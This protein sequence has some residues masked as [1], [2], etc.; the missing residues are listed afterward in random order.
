MSIGFGQ[1]AQ[2]ASATKVLQINEPHRRP[3]RHRG[4]HAARNTPRHPPRG[5]SA[6]REFWNAVGLSSRTGILPL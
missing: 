1:L 6:L 2:S 3:A 5:P 4:R